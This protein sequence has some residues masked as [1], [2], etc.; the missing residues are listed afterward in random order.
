[1]EAAH[2]YSVAEKMSDGEASELSIDEGLMV[3]K[4]MDFIDHKKRMSKK[5]L[6]Q[7]AV[8]DF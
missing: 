8:F 1:M 6:N 5:R 4:I 2:I 3:G 7:V